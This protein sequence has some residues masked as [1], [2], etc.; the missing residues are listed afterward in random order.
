LLFNALSTLIFF[1]LHFA[2]NL[3]AIF[4]AALPLIQLDVQKNVDFP[5]PNLISIILSN[6]YLTGSIPA[7]LGNITNLVIVVFSQNQLA[8]S[9]PHEVM[10]MPK[11]LAL[12]LDNNNLSGG[13]PEVWKMPNIIQLYLNSN[14]LSG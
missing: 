13:I 7:A 6:N 12:F 8:G 14:N 10:Q 9:I 4:F 3:G 5:L 2:N 11:V 1:L